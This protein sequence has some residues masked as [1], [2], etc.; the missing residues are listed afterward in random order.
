[1]KLYY[2]PG[3]CSLIVH[4]MLNELGLPAEFEKVDL[5]VKKTET[6]A[7]Y[8]TINPKGAVPAL[9]LDNGEMLTENAIILQY[10]ADHYKKTDLLPPVGDFQRYHVLE[11]MNFI[12]TDIHK[13]FGPLFSP[14]VPQ[15]L[16]EKVFIPNLE[17]KFTFLD[18]RLAG[19]DFIMSDH[20]TL[21]DIYLF[22]MLTWLNAFKVPL[23]NWKNLPRF[24]EMMKA[25]PS[26]QKSLQEEGLKY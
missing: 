5:K 9:A 14:D 17:K 16:K 26:V 3:A 23:T 19:H 13:S 20:L 6:G 8:Y 4:I 7:D 12:T 18:G 11:T 22:V 10:L 2:A 25:R 15:E 1:M 21:P 24:Y